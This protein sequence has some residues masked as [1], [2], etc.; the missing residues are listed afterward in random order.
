MGPHVSLETMLEIAGAI[1]LAALAV[2]CVSVHM[3]RIVGVAALSLADAWL[4]GR[5]RYRERVEHWH[6]AAHGEP[7]EVVEMPRKRAKS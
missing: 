2:T 3:L 6:K 4:A 1:L 7:A 5:Q